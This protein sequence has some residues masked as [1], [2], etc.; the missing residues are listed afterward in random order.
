MFRITDH[1]LINGPLKCALGCIF[2]LALLS[3]TFSTVNASIESGLQSIKKGELPAP[4]ADPHKQAP[5][6]ELNEKFEPLA[7]PDP[8]SLFG[9]GFG[10]TY[11]IIITMA[12]LSLFLFISMRDW[13][14]F[15]YFLALLLLMIFFFISDE[16]RLLQHLSGWR[17]WNLEPVYRICL[18]GLLAMFTQFSRSF[19]MT[20][21]EEPEA[22]RLLIFLILVFAVSAP[23][24]FIWRKIAYLYIFPLVTFVSLVFT[25]GVGILRLKQGFSPARFF[26]WGQ[27]LFTLGGVTEILVARQVIP[28]NILTLNSIQIGAA[29]MVIL[30]SLAQV[31]RIR[32]LRIEKEAAEITCQALVDDNSQFMWLLDPQGLVRELNAAALDSEKSDKGGLAGKIFSDLDIW[33]AA[34]QTREM[35]STA[36]KKAS[37]GDFVRLEAFGADRM[38]RNIHLD[39]SLKPIKDQDGKV[40]LLITKGKSIPAAGMTQTPSNAKKI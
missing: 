15:W 7:H 8:V 32:T 5:P 4:T 26:I 21:S 6:N 27:P 10:I 25:L 19:L 34:G 28:P 1:S 20:K 37:Q 22:D 12:L 11:G 38:G 2:I 40:L 31:D 14:H 36:I 17:S 30:L 23:L 33:E 13:M 29:F 9:L 3:F 16:K 18:I 24:S 39:L 35:I